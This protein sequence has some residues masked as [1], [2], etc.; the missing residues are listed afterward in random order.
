MKKFIL[1]GMI[2]VGALIILLKKRE[3]DWKDF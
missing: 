2:A 3:N 1:T